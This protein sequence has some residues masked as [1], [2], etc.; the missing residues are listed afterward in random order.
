MNGIYIYIYIFFSARSNFNRFYVPELSKKIL[1]LLKFLSVFM[2]SLGTM[3]VAIVVLCSY[4]PSIYITNKHN[5]P[6]EFFK[7][8]NNWRN[9]NTKIKSLDEFLLLLNHYKLLISNTFNYLSHKSLSCFTTA[10]FHFSFGIS[11]SPND[12]TIQFPWLIVKFI[13]S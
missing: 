7:D 9:A 2:N 3:V 8:N 12:S 5:S 4:F 10:H 11:S 1:L 13:E 6:N